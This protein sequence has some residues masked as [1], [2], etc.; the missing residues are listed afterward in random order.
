MKAK[1]NFNGNEPVDFAKAGKNLLMATHELT[2]ALYE[3]RSLIHG[4]NYQTYSD[5]LNGGGVCV[6][7]IFPTFWYG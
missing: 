4:R 7:G 2:T 5:S 3:V 1:P 6:G